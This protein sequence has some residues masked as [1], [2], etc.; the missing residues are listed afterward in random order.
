MG[1]VV[2]ADQRNS[3]SR[4]TA[5]DP[6]ATN[7]PTC[8]SAAVLGPS[9]GVLARSWPNPALTNPSSKIAS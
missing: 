5:D 6:I 2:V 3:H 1:S 7:T 4:Q 9:A 8:S